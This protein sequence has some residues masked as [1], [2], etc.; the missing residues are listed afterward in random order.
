MEGEEK[1]EVEITDMLRELESFA[2]RIEDLAIEVNNQTA[3]AP[4][5]HRVESIKIFS[6]GSH[7]VS[8]VSNVTLVVLS[9]QGESVLLNWAVEEQVSF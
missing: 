6:G 4:S 5:N 3:F 8:C 9:R 2:Q 1:D 7:F